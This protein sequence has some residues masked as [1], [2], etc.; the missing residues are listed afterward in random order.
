MTDD[1][2]P[3]SA[4]RTRSAF[5]RL[6]NG[7]AHLHHDTSHLSAVHGLPA[8]ESADH[9]MRPAHLLASAGHVTRPY[10]N[11]FSHATF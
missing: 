7:A 8:S 10:G 3:W 5:S 11:E 6:Y 4:H 1:L 9:V 2:S